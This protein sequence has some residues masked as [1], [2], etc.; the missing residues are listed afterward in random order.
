MDS[1]SVLRRAP[2]LGPQHIPSFSKAS[3]SKSGW[4]G[5]ASE[6]FSFGGWEFLRHS[7]TR[8]P[9]NKDASEVWGVMG[10]DGGE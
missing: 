3:T 9:A 6:S 1:S 4:D 10:V 5:G 7:H 2:R 8:A